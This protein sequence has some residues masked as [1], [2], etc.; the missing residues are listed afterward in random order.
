MRILWQKVKIQHTKEFTKVLAKM[1]ARHL[2]LIRV[3][4]VIRDIEGKDANKSM[5][6]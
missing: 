6:D 5:P 1:V 2:L 4:K 3:E